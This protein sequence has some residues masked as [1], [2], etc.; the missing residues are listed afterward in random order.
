MT[1]G[2]WRKKQQQ[3][4][5]AELVAAPSHRAV[6]HPAWPLLKADLANVLIV[7]A[8]PLAVA[9]GLDAGVVVAARGAPG[10]NHDG[11]EFKGQQALRT[12]RGGNYC[13]DVSRRRL[14][15]CCF[16]RTRL[17]G[18]FYHERALLL[19]AWLTGPDLSK[20]ELGCCNLLATVLSKK[21]VSKASMIKKDE[22]DLEWGGV[23]QIYYLL[24]SSTFLPD[25]H[26]C[27]YKTNGWHW[28][29]AG[30]YLNGQQTTTTRF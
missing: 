18:R 25:K 2:G 5:S 3:H 21:K 8:V 10:V 15:R 17:R 11:E 19:R 9:E 30:V 6:R 24:K 29:S 16:F 22:C 1:R 12:H 27:G 26:W 7:E 4:R 13:P 20:K 14:R 28:T 23:F